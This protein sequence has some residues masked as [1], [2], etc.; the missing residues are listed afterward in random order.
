MVQNRTVWFKHR[1]MNLY[2][3]TAFAW[4]S[5]I[6]QLPLSIIE[7][8]LFAIL[9][10]FMIGFST[11]ATLS[12]DLSLKLRSRVELQ[13][14]LDCAC[15]R[16]WSA[17]AHACY[18]GAGVLVATGTSKWPLA[19]PSHA[20][21]Q[22]GA[23]YFFMA[24]TVLVSTSLA[25]TAGIRFLGCLTQSSAIANSLM[26]L[27]LLLLVVNSGFCYRVRRAAAL[28]R[29][30]VL[31][32]SP[33]RM[34]SAHSPLTSSRRRAGSRPRSVRQATRWAT[35]RSA[36]SASTRRG[37]CHAPTCSEAYCVHPL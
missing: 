20:H 17:C 3:A 34:R 5:A 19:S 36:C 28:D 7:T 18:S 12:S 30:P 9:Y 25:L 27:S 23:Q 6:V 35:A 24:C 1:D 8:L 31:G 2:T 13:L 29:V 16:W 32:Q 11:G 10:Y 4:S 26:G 37:M 21:V 14:F 15:P 33:S 22:M